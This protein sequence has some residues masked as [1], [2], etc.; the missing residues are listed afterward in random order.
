MNLN[1]GALSNVD[2]GPIAGKLV[3]MGAPIIGGLIG[4]PVGSVVATVATSVGGLLDVPPTPEAIAA[5]LDSD[6]AA[7][8][9]IRSFEDEKRNDLL[10]LQAEVQKVQIE[11]VNT[12][13]RAE[14]VS[15]DKYQRWARPTNMYAVGLVTG[16]YG[17][18][19]VAAAIDGLISKNYEGLKT[20]M[21]NGPSLGLALAPAGAVAGVTAWQQTK[22]KLAGVIQRPPPSLS[23]KSGR[24]RG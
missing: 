6:P 17:L 16:G 9:K 20:L 19:I 8:E 1:M 24:G 11:Q 5:K 21:D 14:L 13:A 2:W 10:I 4:G 22:E 3:V 7:I 15:G 23:T 18:A 12:T